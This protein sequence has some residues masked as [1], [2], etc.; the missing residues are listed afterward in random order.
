MESQIKW[1]NG[2]DV[3]PK[4]K[5]T[6]ILIT[7]IYISD[8]SIFMRTCAFLFDDFIIG[9]YLAQQFCIIFHQNIT[10]N[11]VID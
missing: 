8:K 10:T 11:T 3:P 1:S 7:N 9:T 6:V 5:K 4:T 2:V